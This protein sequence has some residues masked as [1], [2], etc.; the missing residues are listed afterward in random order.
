M[1]ACDKV[2]LLKFKN[3]EGVIYDNDWIVG[4]KYEDTEDGNEDYNEED[5]EKWDYTKREN[6]EGED[7]EDEEGINEDELAYL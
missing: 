6:D 2:T 7:L 5:Q 3:R 1:A 4:V